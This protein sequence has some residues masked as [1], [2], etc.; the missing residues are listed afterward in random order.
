MTTAFNTTESWALVRHES[1]KKREKESVKGR[2]N[3]KK[4]LLLEKNI[5]E[6]QK[7]KHPPKKGLQRCSDATTRLNFLSGITRA[8]SMGIISGSKFLYS[9]PMRPQRSS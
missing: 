3:E 8:G 6:E 1:K 7:V 4:R 2:K 9:T 5:K